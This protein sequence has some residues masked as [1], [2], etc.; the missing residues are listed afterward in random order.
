MKVTATTIDGLNIADNFEVK[1]VAVW[2]GREV[3]H[4][5]SQESIDALLKKAKESGR[6]TIS[7]TGRIDA[8]EETPNYTGGQRSVNELYIDGQK[9]DF[10][11]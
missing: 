8:F 4:E 2:I 3:L 10:K 11:N 6:L 1:R 5:V 9:I 7:Q